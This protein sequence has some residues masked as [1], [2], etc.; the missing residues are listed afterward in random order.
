MEIGKKYKTR[1]I[2][3]VASYFTKNE[4]YHPV[5]AGKDSTKEQVL[6]YLNTHN[7]VEDLSEYQSRAEGAVQWVKSE[8]SSDWIDNIRSFMTKKEVGED[9]VG[10]L[11]S[12]FSGY[13]NF[14]KK[15]DFKKDLLKSEYRGKPKDKII[16]EVRSTKH[17]S[18]G[19]SKYNENKEFHIFQIIDNLNNVYIWFADRDYSEDLKKSKRIGA[20]V[21]S[22]NERE[23]I[24]QT[25]VQVSDIN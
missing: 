24:K 14:L 13:D 2:L 7:T 1:D 5:S 12:A 22:H 9:A 10:I 25:I 4:G 8:K 18:S 19:K 15:Q 3:L 20:I 6:T 11:S 17:I 21:K 23:G 16:I